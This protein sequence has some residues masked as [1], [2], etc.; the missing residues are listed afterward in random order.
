MWVYRELLHSPHQDPAAA[1]QFLETY[2]PKTVWSRFKDEILSHMLVHEIVSTVQ[3]NVIVDFGGLTLISVCMNETDRTIPDVAR[4]YVLA[5][6][7]LE[8]WQLKRDLL[9]LDWT[10][11][12]ETQ[13][14]A[15]MRIEDALRDFT[16]WML[17]T[18]TEAELH[19]I[20]PER[21]AELRRGAAALR[22]VTPG[23]MSEALREE[24]GQV[25]E[26]CVTGGLPVDLAQRMAVA[27]VGGAT[28]P[29][30]QVAEREK[31]EPERV[32][33][34][35][36]ALGD[37]LKLLD[38]SQRLDNHVTDDKWEALAIRRMRRLFASYHVEL[39]RRAVL[40]LDRRA[41]ASHAMRSMESGSAGLSSLA[42]DLQ[43]VARDG[44]KLAALVVLSERFRRV[45]EA[46]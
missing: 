40:H 18:H 31:V 29:I 23:C 20:T 39:T 27:F 11:T 34:V 4:A 45:V 12:S 25:I 6:D 14:D 42:S 41:G 8:T 19:A 33:D 44:F 30:L 7:I 1:L 28:L 13:Y 37:A 15:L 35:Y 10:I 5:N 32:A 21:V 24:V 26:A 22:R 43:Q 38:L 36:F 9:A 3:T 17:H 46:A 16:L 2:F